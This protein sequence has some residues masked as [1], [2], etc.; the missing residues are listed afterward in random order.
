MDPPGLNGMNYTILLLK[1]F[2]VGNFIV[3]AVIDWRK[4]RLPD[5]LQLS[6]I[7]IITVIYFLSPTD[8]RIVMAGLLVG[9]VTGLLIFYLSSYVYKQQAFGFGDVKLL[10]VL[11][12]LSGIHY[13]LYVL[14]GGTVMATVFALT[15]ITLGKLNWRSKIPL[16]SFLCITAIVFVIIVL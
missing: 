6:A 15:G 16:G 13:F 7:I 1:I 11:G 4:F 10:A 2:L 9:L 14:I 3:L 8:W 12:Y 5:P